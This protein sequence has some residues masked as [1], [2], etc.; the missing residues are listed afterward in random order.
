MILGLLRAAGD[1]MVFVSLVFGADPAISIESPKHIASTSGAISSGEI[2]YTLINVTEDLE[3]RTVCPLDFEAAQAIVQTGFD[4]RNIQAIYSPVAGGRRV[5]THELAI[6]DQAVENRAD[7][8]EPC[9]WQTTIW[10][11]GQR[12]QASDTHFGGRYSSLEHLTDEILLIIPSD[13][14]PAR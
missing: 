4:R 10:Y 14:I 5:L 7:L 8:I 13:P 2:L 6:L 11:D 9:L 1:I 3:A 12:L